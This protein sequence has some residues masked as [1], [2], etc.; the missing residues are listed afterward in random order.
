MDI[1]ISVFG[2]FFLFDVVVVL[3]V[4]SN[5]LKFLDLFQICALTYCL[6]ASGL[7]SCKAIGHAFECG[8]IL[9]LVLRLYEHS[10]FGGP[11]VPRVTQLASRV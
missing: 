7:S 11:K 5:G 8:H 9:E 10:W 3:Y 2:K 1:Q 6:K 4:I